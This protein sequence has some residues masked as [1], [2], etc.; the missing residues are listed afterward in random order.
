MKKVRK[1]LFLGQFY[2]GLS[3]VFHLQSI[4][5]YINS[6]YQQIYGLNSTHM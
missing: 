3:S 2:D 1:L 5:T 6:F 4:F